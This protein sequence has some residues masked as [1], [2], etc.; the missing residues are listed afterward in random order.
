MRYASNTF[1]L[2][3]FLLWASGYSQVIHK[4]QLSDF[5][6]KVGVVNDR[7]NRIEPEL[8]AY[9]IGN[10]PVTYTER[11][12]NTVSYRFGFHLAK[13]YLHP[14]L[15][16]LG[17]S[18]VT[19]ILFPEMD[20][21]EKIPALLSFWQIEEDSLRYLHHDLDTHPSFVGHTRIEKIVPL[22]QDE[23]LIILTYRGD[24]NGGYTYLF[25]RLNEDPLQLY[26]SRWRYAENGTLSKQFGFSESKNYLDVYAHIM[27]NLGLLVQNAI[28]TPKVDK[29]NL[30]SILELNTRG[31]SHLKHTMRFFEGG[32]CE[33]FSKHFSSQRSFTVLPYSFSADTSELCH[34][35]PGSF[36]C[37]PEL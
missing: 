34:P 5:T 10:P 16:K 15:H 18:G 17:E 3:V 23:F 22:A 4:D 28:E 20:S 19:A 31:P 11:G 36:F 14:Q 9:K 35:G 26:K 30:L 27:E 32:Y 24:Q 2:S 13:N 29:T 7:F 6:A 21:H 37:T 8:S 25:Y 1:I 12:Q 33:L